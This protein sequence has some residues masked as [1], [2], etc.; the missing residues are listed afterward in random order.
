MASTLTT[1]DI[2]TVAVTFLGTFL[3]DIALNGAGYL[4]SAELAGIAA[5]GVLGYHYVSGNVSAAAK[6]P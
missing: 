6:T 2:E 1:T 3:T 5:L 4:P